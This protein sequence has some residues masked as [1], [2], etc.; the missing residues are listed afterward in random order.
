MIDDV[1]Q[2]YVSSVLLGV[3]MSP[4]ITRGELT[5]MYGQLASEGDP[6]A[7]TRALNH[8]CRQDGPVIE[9]EGRLR[10]RRPG[11]RSTS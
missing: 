3:G 9:E 11:E 8:C 7:F 1:A 6:D 4:G 5:E 10:L 2:P